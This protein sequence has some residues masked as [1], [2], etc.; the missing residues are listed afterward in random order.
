[1]Y[2]QTFGLKQILLADAKFAFYRQTS[3]Q[4]NQCTYKRNLCKAI[5]FTETRSSF[6]CTLVCL[7]ACLIEIEILQN[8]I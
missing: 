7:S 2:V 6:E 4:A 5:L 8:S 3:R 1:M